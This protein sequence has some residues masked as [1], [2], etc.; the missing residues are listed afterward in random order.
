M[1]LGEGKWQFSVDTMIY[2]GE[3]TV[4]VR[5][6]EGEY[7]VDLALTDMELPALVLENFQAEGNVLTGIAHTDLLRG[8]NIPFSFTFEGDVVNGF[9]K[10]PFMGKIKLTNGK[11]IVQ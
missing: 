2:R 5:D 6:K 7:D 3:G 1:L 11:R 10:V 4:E 8:K 9:I